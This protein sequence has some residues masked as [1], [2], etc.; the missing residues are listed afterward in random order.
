LRTIEWR[1]GVVFTIDQSKLPHEQVVVKITNCREMADAIKSMKIRGA[2]LLGVA[3]GLGL[4]IAAYSSNAE[5][6]EALIVELNRCAQ[7]LRRTR[8]TA[9][10]LFWALKRVL[11]KV[12][13]VEGDANAGKAVVIKEAL[14]MAEDD[15]SIN[16][17][18]GKLG[19]TLIE[20]GDTILTHCNAGSL[21]TVDYG[22]AL[23]VLRA[24]WEGGKRICVVATETRPLLQGA[25]L[26]AYELLR[27]GIPVKLITDN[28][29]GY[30]LSSGLIHKIVV[31]ADRIVKDAVVNKIGTYTLA[32]VAKEN[33]VPFYVAAPE[34][35]FDHERSSKDVII[36]ERRGEEVTTV[37]GIQVAPKNI[38]VLN[39]AFD[40]TPFEYITAIITEKGVLYQKDLQNLTEKN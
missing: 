16:K 35:T 13:A 18:I 22:T 6:K 5:T 36:E 10:N 39:P 21:A 40:I 25:R 1:D 29:V 28:M 34:S 4:A 30:T 14:R 12:R 11:D 7:S 17:M 2:P 3:A 8:P 20:D 27:D 24:A 26:T 32:V 31:G 15:V 23:G 9:M 19:S 37:Q 38:A 33:N